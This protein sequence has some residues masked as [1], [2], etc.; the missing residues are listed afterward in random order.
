MN[1]RTK[2]TNKPLRPIA[3]AAVRRLVPAAAA[4]VAKQTTGHASKQTTKRSGML[5]HAVSVGDPD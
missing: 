4:V 1:E 2:Q 3:P 5:E